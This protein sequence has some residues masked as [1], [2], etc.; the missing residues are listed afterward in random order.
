MVSA[1]AATRWMQQVPFHNGVPTLPHLPWL[2]ALRDRVMKDRSLER[3]W[4]EA[5][6]HL[7]LLTADDVLGVEMPVWREGLRRPRLDEWWPSRRLQ[8]TIFGP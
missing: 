6:M 1:S 7:P 5:F 4:V 8:P 2:F 3:N